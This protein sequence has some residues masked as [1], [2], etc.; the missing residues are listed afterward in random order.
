MCARASVHVCNVHA[1]VC[2]GHCTQGRIHDF[3]KGGSESGVDL[4]G[5]LI[6]VLYL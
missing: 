6:L 5:G 2:A 1:C 4:E 3:L